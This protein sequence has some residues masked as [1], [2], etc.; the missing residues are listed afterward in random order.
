MSR[1]CR[2]EAEE[3]ALAKENKL[4]AQAAAREAAAAAAV[5]AADQIVKSPSDFSCHSYELFVGQEKGNDDNNK[6]KMSIRSIES[7]SDQRHKQ[8]NNNH[9]A[10]NK[11]RKV[12]AVSI[13]LAD[14]RSD[15]HSASFWR[16]VTRLVLLST[17]IPPTPR[18]YESNLCEAIRFD[19][20]RRQS[21]ATD[22][23]ITA[24]GVA[25]KPG[26]GFFPYDLALS[27][28][29]RA[30]SVYLS[31]SGSRPGW[32]R[33]SSGLLGN[34]IERA[35]ARAQTKTRMQ[36]EWAIRRTR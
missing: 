32:R 3:A 12:S 15:L 7:A 18:S 9:S 13:R 36:I 11:V 10:A 19:S 14:V 29:S 17:S 35:P 34:R 6:E 16:N 28:F 21:I 5:A 26:A 33:D 30:E 23:E 22:D 8:I 20:T 31:Q 4:A 24:P 1:L 2:Q 27:R 25:S